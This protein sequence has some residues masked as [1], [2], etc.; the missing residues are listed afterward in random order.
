[1]AVPLA[2]WGRRRSART[3]RDLLDG[4][5][6]CWHEA[7][8]LLSGLRH[9]VLKHNTTVLP[10]V[11]AA[12]ARGD[13]A[14]WDALAARMP[15]LL[16]RFGAYL[17]AIEALGRRHGLRV[18]L[19]GKDPVL[20]PM[21]RA[22]RRL[23]RARRPPDDLL[24]LSE[25]INGAGYRAIGQMVREICVLPV[26]EPLVRGVYTRVSAEPGFAGTPLPALE[27]E[28]RGAGLAVRMFRAEL[29]DILANLL[30]NALAAGARRVAVVL[31]A[32]D[33]PVTGHAWVEVHVRD[34]APGQ[35]T[36]AMIRSRF[37]GR[38]LGLAVDLVNKHGGTISVQPGDGD[39]AVVVQIPG[40]EAA[41]VEVEEWTVA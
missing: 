19:R 8:R 25:T 24:E 29:E 23:A 20:A 40:V 14:P 27:V 36:N 33:D 35:L 28:E 2:Y 37:I 1:V 12:L 11:A 4:H 13:R 32:V 34:D 7:A 17:F 39:K 22:M 5:P 41:S 18:D 31:D 9:E 16:D 3:L 10:D 21:W 6:S 30:R 38:G 26:D 15:D